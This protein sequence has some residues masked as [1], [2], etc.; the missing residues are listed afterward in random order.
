MEFLSWKETLWIGNSLNRYV[1]AITP[2]ERT[3]FLEIQRDY[4]LP[5]Y[6]SLP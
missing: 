5:Q 4:I 1:N 2:C 3:W 6:E